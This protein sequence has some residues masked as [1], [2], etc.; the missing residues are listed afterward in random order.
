MS[1]NGMLLSNGPYPA[2]QADP[3]M[4]SGDK[5]DKC[6]DGISGAISLGQESAALVRNRGLVLEFNLC[7][8]N[9]MSVFQ[10]A[11]RPRNLYILK[12]RTFSG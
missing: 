2:D 10:T 4:H 1:T 9:I 11:H 7:I 12:F 8:V 6:V 3:C 5:P